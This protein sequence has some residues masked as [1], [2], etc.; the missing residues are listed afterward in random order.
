MNAQV[1]SAPGKLNEN[2]L[3]LVKVETPEPR[4]NHVR[5]RIHTCAVCHTDL[6]LVQGDIH[7]SKIPII[8]GH[9]IVGTVD[10]LGENAA[11]F[12][13]GTRVGV[14]WLNWID[15][16][17]RWYGTDREN[18]CDNIRF[19][20]FDV[21]GGYAEYIT[22]N[23][24]FCYPIPPA[25]SNEHAA[26]LLCAGV[27]GF[28]ALKLS[29]IERGDRLGLFG[30]GASAH[31]VQQIAQH[32]GKSVFVF[33]RSA[34]HQ[35][36]ARELGAAWVGG[37]SDTPPDRLDSAIIFAPVGDLVVRALER[38]ERG[39]TVVHAGVHSTP[40]PRFDYDLLYHERTI[41]SAANSTR[42]DVEDLLRMAAEIPIRTDVTTY[43]LADANRALH[44]VQNSRVSGAAV[45]AVLNE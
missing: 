28:R 2:S 16:E 13:V 40:I 32:W 1:L 7:P 5:I 3:T 15:S 24:D 33:T 22:V 21:D 45:L 26:P 4:P 38:L 9:Q 36:H 31:I 20:G 44:D 23:Q 18:L 42:R 39:G 34:L 6:H 35:A 17:C 25:F 8:P 14:P 12:A 19:T 27:I 43:P 11:R 10:A 37:S 41:R 29:E 30:F